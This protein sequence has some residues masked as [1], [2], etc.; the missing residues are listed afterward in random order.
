MI[1]LYGFVNLMPLVDLAVCFPSTVCVMM[2]YPRERERDRERETETET[3]RQRHMV[4]EREK[5]RQP[6]RQT[7]RER[8]RESTGVSMHFIP[9][10]ILKI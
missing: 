2:E 7:T 4:R 9:H 10:K 6:D 8:E 1:K 5:E 3:E